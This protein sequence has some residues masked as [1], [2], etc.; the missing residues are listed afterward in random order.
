MTSKIYD[1]YTEEERILV[2]GEH[3]G[4]KTHLNNREVWRRNMM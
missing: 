4:E 1:K 2:S 3:K